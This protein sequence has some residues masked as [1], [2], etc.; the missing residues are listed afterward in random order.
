MKEKGFKQFTMHDHT[1]LWRSE[2][3]K[4]LAKALGVMVQKTWYWYDTWVDQVTKHCQE[5]AGKYGA[6]A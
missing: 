5:N 4:N 6:K 2:D 3:A 1:T